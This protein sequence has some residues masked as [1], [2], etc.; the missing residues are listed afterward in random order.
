MAEYKKIYILF[1]IKFTGN[2]WNYMTTN[3]FQGVYT[4]IDEIRKIIG[5][6][7]LVDYEDESF[8]YYYTGYVYITRKVKI[9]G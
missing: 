3:Y 2:Q 7:P 9:D 6:V 8:D 5:D 1:F 4:S